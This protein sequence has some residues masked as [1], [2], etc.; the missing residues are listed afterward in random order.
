MQAEGSLLRS[1]EP[2]I[3]PYLESYQYNPQPST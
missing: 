2:A 1:P 3:Y